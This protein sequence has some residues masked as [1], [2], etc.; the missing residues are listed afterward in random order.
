MLIAQLSI[1]S[2]GF[3]EVE[4]IYECF[5]FTFDFPGMVISLQDKPNVLKKNPLLPKYSFLKF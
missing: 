2:V 1:C 5:E 3:T 4:C